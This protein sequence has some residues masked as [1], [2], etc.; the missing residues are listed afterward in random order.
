MA[1]GHLIRFGVFEVN[2]QTGELRKHGLRIKLREQPFQILSL[3]LEHPGHVVT[4]QEL[5]KKL[6]AADT[7]VDFDRGLNRGRQ[8]VA[9]RLE[10]L[11]REFTL[12]RDLPQTRVPVHCAGGRFERCRR[13]GDHCS[14]GRP[15][16]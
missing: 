9:R 1:K 14:T 15:E 13:S 2:L 5:Q 8:P 3:L 6:W 16:T 11:G 4:R 7:F 10:R 12:H